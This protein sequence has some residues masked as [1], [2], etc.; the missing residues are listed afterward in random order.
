MRSGAFRR[1]LALVAFLTLIALAGCSTQTKR[2]YIRHLS[3]TISPSMSRPLAS[4]EAPG[5]VAAVPSDR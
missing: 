2:D 4:A 5:R 1:G 3:A